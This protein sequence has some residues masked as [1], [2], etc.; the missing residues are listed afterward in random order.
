MAE[1]EAKQRDTRQKGIGDSL[2]SR[3]RP[4]WGV[5]R[6]TVREFRE[7]NLIDWAAALTYY[8]VISL[9]PGAIIVS[10]LLGS[11]SPAAI[12]SLTDTIGE[13]D[14]RGNSVV[15]QLLER[16]QQS[17]LPA[18]PLAGIGIITALWTA[19]AYIGAFVRAANAIYETEEGRPLWKTVPLRLVLTITIMVLVALCAVGILVSGRVAATLE[20][21][22]GLGSV[23]FTVWAI[24]KWPAMAVLA[25]IAFA[26]LYWAAPN[27]RQ[28]GFRWLSP[29]SVLAVFL[30][31]TAS[32]GFVFY[33]TYFGSYNTLYGP[34]AGVIV[35]LIWLWLTNVAILL[36]AEFNAEI[37][38]GHNIEQ[39][40]STDAEPI[41][42]PRDEPN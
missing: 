23:A 7:D 6:R 11:A 17:Q 14:D 33:T 42:P 2:A 29:G 8:S 25:S 39:G 12:R 22:L 34:L 5:L 21:W 31:I 19:S 32:A 40:E 36:G 41:L 13:V 30:W 20:Q 38:R 26:L 18:G 4:W 9:F 27:A 10:V 28:P 37:A 16:L 3:W 35:F 24:A 1:D 15:V